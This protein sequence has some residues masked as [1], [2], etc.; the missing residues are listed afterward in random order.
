[1]ALGAL[2]LVFQFFREYKNERREQEYRIYQNAMNSTARACRAIYYVDVDTGVIDT[3][4]PLGEDGRPRRSTYESEVMDRF[5]YGVVAEEHVGLVT[6]FLEMSNILRRLEERDHIELQFKRSMFESTSAKSAKR[7]TS[8][9]RSR[10]R[11]P[12]GGRAG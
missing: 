10:S 5:R 1:M 3:V 12:S 9:A 2:L 4:Y 7:A 6:D 8:G 11:R